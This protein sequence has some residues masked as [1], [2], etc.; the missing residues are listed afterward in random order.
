[1]FC[2]LGFPV[3][4]N[5]QSIRHCMTEYGQVSDWMAGLSLNEYLFMPTDITPGFLER[6][7]RAYDTDFPEVSQLL[8]Q[9]MIFKGGGE[10][11]GV[12]NSGVGV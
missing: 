9:A 7:L 12:E 11:V 3:F 5:R 10:E 2:V 1:M 8:V 6:R 4:P